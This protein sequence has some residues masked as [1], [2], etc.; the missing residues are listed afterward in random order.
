MHL[1]PL[2]ARRHYGMLREGHWPLGCTG[3]AWKEL[4]NQKTWDWCKTLPCS[5]SQQAI[6]P[7]TIPKAPS[8][9]GTPAAS[10]APA[11]PAAPEAAAAPTYDSE[12]SDGGSTGWLVGLH[13]CGDGVPGGRVC[14]S[15][16]GRGG[17]GVRLFGLVGS[18][19]DED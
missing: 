8:T 10:A 18:I 15:S 16:S 7:P 2:A 13:R 6:A 4:F 3:G 19:G 11:A 1:P 12:V 17:C 5:G 9:S 14:V